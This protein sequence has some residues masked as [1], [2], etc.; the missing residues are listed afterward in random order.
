MKTLFLRFPD[1][2]AALAAFSTVT[3]QEV[4]TLGDV[5][6][7]VVVSGMLCDVDPIGALTHATGSVDAEGAPIV[8]PVEGWHANVWTP[9]EAVTPEAF[10]AVEVFPATPDR[11]FG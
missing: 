9:D 4:A 1:E 11:V 2:A 8:E 10:A 5:P 7:K 6:P 3:G